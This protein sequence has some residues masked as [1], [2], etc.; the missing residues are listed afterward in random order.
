MKRFFCIFLWI[1]SLCLFFGVA[2]FSQKETEF[3]SAES[4]RI[5][6]LLLNKSKNLSENFDFSLLQ[7]DL[8]TVHPNDVR[9]EDLKERV[10]WLEYLI[11]E[12]H[13]I[14][15]LL[16]PLLYFK[17][18]EQEYY[19]PNRGGDV[20]L[21]SGTYLAGEVFH[22]LCEPDPQQLK[23]IAKSVEGIYKITHIT[24]VA[25]LLCRFSI[26]LKQ[27][28]SARI[29]PG[30]K[31]ENLPW[32][33]L[34]LETPSDLPSEYSHMHRQS[35][36]NDCPHFQKS[37][38]GQ[39]LT[40][41][42]PYI[43]SQFY[44]T[45]TT[46]DQLTGIVLGLAVTICALETQQLSRY[47]VALDKR[48]QELSNLILNTACEIALDLLIYLEENQW[49]LKDPFVRKSGT[50]AD[51]VSDLLK[52][53]VQM[54]ARRALM[55]LF[56]EQSIFREE[57]PRNEIPFQMQQQIQKGTKAYQFLKNEDSE[58]LPFGIRRLEG[59]TNLFSSATWYS[60]TP[61]YY[62]WNLRTMR[63]FTVLLLDAPFPDAERYLP[64]SWPL[65]T[66]APKKI[67]ERNRIWMEFW[68]RYLWK[69]IGRD[70]NVWFTYLYNYARRLV[71][72]RHL[73]LFLPPSGLF[74]LQKKEFDY[75]FWWREDWE[76]LEKLRD[77]VL[78]SSSALYDG[79]QQTIGAGLERA[80]FHLRSIA[81][82]PIRSYTRPTEQ[83]KQKQ[84]EFCTTEQYGR[85]IIPPHLRPFIKFWIEG[86]EPNEMDSGT[87]ID[88]VGNVEGL[89]IDLPVL[90]WLGRLSGVLEYR[91]DGFYPYEFV[92]PSKT[93]EK[94]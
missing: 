26:P 18:N 83:L 49:S 80:H 54:L 59:M 75:W 66:L 5:V 72:E 24:G 32:Y 48:E 55:N 9:P 36:G 46:R 76:E 11:H 6:E 13:E 61:N 21:F 77:M 42:Q 67:N 84:L 87:P 88:T 56:R 33:H 44:Y 40:P 64:D 3:T 27:V 43:E 25:G 38:L 47:G 31:E 93:K 50:S 81:I 14:D 57:Q 90:Y 82:T 7:K 35:A 10:L 39:F 51:H 37:P 2:L 45:R 28:I 12:R 15:G 20:A 30:A 74:A 73:G 1:E 4:R 89:S 65:E 69:Q 63:V 8:M 19:Q 85:K 62:A 58:L 86:T 41:E 79:N 91:Y 17:E 78:F 92:L 29:L 60:L 34:Y 71:F 70:T 23:R 52:L 94:K 53:S 16:F 22:F 68:N